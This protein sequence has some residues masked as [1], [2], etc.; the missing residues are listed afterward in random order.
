MH[1]PKSKTDNIIILFL[2]SP[3]DKKTDH[4]HAGICYRYGCIYRGIKYEA[5]S[6][7]NVTFIEIMQTMPQEKL[8][9]T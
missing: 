8:T 3:K 7:T 5:C 6:E 1:I 4:M 2:F 9:I